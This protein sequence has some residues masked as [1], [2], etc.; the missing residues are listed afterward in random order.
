[1]DK[2]S[3]RI[4]ANFRGRKERDDPASEANKRKERSK[5]DPVFQSETYMRRHKLLELFDVLGQN[6]VA[7]RPADPRA[8]LIQ[9]LTKLKSL[10]E[11]SSQLHFFSTTDIETLFSMYDVSGQGLTALQ[12]AEALRAMGLDGQVKV[13]KGVDRFDRN[14]F[15]SILPSLP[16][17]N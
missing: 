9:E 1:M 3:V 14:A 11:P 15:F 8:F 5:N 6:L 17:V 10:P 4:Q 13:P 7:A 16:A 2:A 12:C